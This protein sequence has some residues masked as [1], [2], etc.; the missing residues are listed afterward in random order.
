MT[1]TTY[2]RLIASASGLR[3]RAARSRANRRGS[4]A[5]PNGVPTLDATNNPITATY[6][7]T[8][9]MQVIFRMNQEA[10]A[11][12]STTASANVERTKR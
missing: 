3:T 6:V 4:V 12:Y 1:S 2:A 8:Q 9:R 11:R 5:R 7:R 10:Y